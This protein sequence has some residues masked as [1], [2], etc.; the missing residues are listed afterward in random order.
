MSDETHERETL[1]EG[2]ESSFWR[3]FRDHTQQEW[4]VG[5]VRYAAAV[6]R[7]AEKGD[8][9]AVA[10]LRMVVFAQS[11]IERLFAYPTE[12]LQQLRGQL[13]RP[14]ELTASRRGPGL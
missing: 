8:A 2:L 1:T 9:E 12:R 14:D 5:G 13:R 11:E 10:Y 7:A 6:K 4:G 3:W